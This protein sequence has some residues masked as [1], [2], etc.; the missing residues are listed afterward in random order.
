MPSVLPIALGNPATA[1]DPVLVDEVLELLC[2]R[3]GAV[4]VDCTFGAGGH[5]GR[6]AEE[7]GADG[8]YIAIDQDP[9]AR[10]FFDV[11]SVHAA[12]Q[13]RFIRQNFATALDELAEEGVHA[14]AILMD[15]GISSMQID[16]PERGFSYA[17][18][19]PL[20]MRMDPDQQISATTLI[21][22]SSEADLA[23]WFREYGEERYARQ[24]ARAIVR[25]R[26]IDPISTT[27]DLVEIVRS[28]VPAGALFAGGHPAKRVFQALRIVVNAELELLPPALE[29]AFRVLAVDGVLAVIS[30]H[31]LED[32]AVK[33]F[34]RARSQG[35]ICPPDMPV[36]GCGRSPEARALNSRAVMPGAPEM[37]RNPRSRSAR[38]R[39]IVKLD[40]A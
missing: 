27:G 33:R 37:H 20:D 19:A 16:R 35:C 25:R 40:A 39:A 5:A 32:R 12:C 31:S 8:I 17:R 18:Q 4:V 10:P 22:E 38:L 13:T 24:I 36:C 3:P 9:E 29:S 15:L 26:V 11:F 34:M 30:F 23:R 1:H 28:A 2:L 21:A 6:I 14:D 7:I